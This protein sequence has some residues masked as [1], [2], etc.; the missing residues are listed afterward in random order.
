MSARRR[1]PSSRGRPPETAMA[2]RELGH[3]G[4]GEAPHGTLD[5]VSR[6]ARSLV[7]PADDLR[8]PELLAGGLQPIDD[9]RRV[10]EHRLIATEFL[11]RQVGERLT[12]ALQP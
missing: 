3:D 12:D 5:L 7:E 4:L 1:E 10:P 8:E 6:Q 2:L 9:L 11:V